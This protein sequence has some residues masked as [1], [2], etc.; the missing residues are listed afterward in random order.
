[1]FVGATHLRDMEDA[2][3]ISPD[4]ESDVMKARLPVR[5]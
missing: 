2:L 4:E 1:M 3:S 5:G